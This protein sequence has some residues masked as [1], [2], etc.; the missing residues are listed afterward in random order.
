MKPDSGARYFIQQ[1]MFQGE[2]FHGGAGCKDIEI[3]LLSNGFKPIVFPYQFD[4]SLIAKV[5]RLLIVFKYLI[6]LPR[7]SIVFFSNTRVCE[8]T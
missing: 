7:R 6:G 8:G 5:S 1:H 4:F 2:V 3:T